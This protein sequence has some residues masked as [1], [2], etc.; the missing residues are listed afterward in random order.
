MGKEARH[1]ATLSLLRSGSRSSTATGRACAK[2]GA[3][4]KGRLVHPV[5]DERIECD[6]PWEAREIAIGGPE[7]AHAVLAAECGHASIV[8][9]P[10]G[11]GRASQRLPHNVP[12]LLG[13]PKQG[14]A[15]RR[16]PYVHLLERFFERGRWSKRFWIG[17]DGEE[18]VNARPWD[19]P[20]ISTGHQIAET[21][22][23]S[24]I[25]LRFVAVCVDENV[26]I[27]RDHAPFST[28]SSKNPG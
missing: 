14:D 28:S 20:G 19:A 18:L 25:E 10:A 2:R 13:L 12:V 22:K 24:S 9:S 8:Y 16:E 7:F 5:I 15:R 17:H 6:Q 11:C 27:D 4:Y 26:G 3:I 1:T 21:T 23:S